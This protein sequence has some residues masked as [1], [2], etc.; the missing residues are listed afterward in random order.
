MGGHPAIPPTQCLLLGGCFLRYDLTKWVKVTY[1]N[2]LSCGA[3]EPNGADRRPIVVVEDPQIQ[4]LIQGLLGRSGYQAQAAAQDYCQ[5]LLEGGSLPSV[6]ITNQ[7]S[8]FLAFAEELPLLYVAALPDPRLASMF[9]HC[10]VLR[11]PFHVSELVASVD[12]LIHTA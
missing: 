9:R 2:D 4:K 1:L 5:T 3:A 8:L 11:K 6:L 7:P 10:R 12:Q